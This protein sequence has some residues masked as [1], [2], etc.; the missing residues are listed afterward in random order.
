MFS[1]NMDVKDSNETKVLDI[2]EALQIYL[3]TSKIG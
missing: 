3:A 2:L 1:K